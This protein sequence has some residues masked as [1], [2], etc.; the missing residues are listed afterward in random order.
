MKI[1]M[2]D[3]LR[4]IL[5]YIRENLVWIVLNIRRNLLIYGVKELKSSFVLEVFYFCVLYC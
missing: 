4:C 5:F 2:F 1:K 3:F